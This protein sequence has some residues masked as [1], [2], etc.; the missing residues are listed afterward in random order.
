MRVYSLFFGFALAVFAVGQAWAVPTHITV[1]VLGRDATFVGSATGGIEITLK[2]AADGTILAQGV[3]QGTP[4]SGDLV[5][6]EP[7]ERGKTISTEKS[8]VFNATIDIDEPT[9]VQVEAWGPLKRETSAN[10]ITQ[11]MWVMP[12]KHITAGDGWLLEMPGLIVEW[13]RPSPDYVFTGGPRTVELRANITPMCGCGIKPGGNWPPERYETAV[14]LKYDGEWVG[15]YPLQFGGISSL[16]QVEVELK[17][18]GT[19]EAIVYGYDPANG[20]TGVARTNF[21]LK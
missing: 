14:I 15:E 16:F 10:L 3:T 6:V 7:R 4:G 9:Q 1:R 5:M 12:G 2:N 18:R 8:A 17:K 19:Y 11:T 13:L 21:T 20:N